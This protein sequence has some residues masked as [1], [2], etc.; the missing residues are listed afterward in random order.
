MRD[1]VFKN[2]TSEDKK[3][4]VITTVEVTDQEGVHSIIQRRFICIIKE[5]KGA[6]G[7]TPLPYVYVL[8]ERNHQAQKERFFCRMKGSM[9][10]VNREKVYS[11]AYLH[12]L[13]ISLTA[14]PQDLAR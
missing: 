1:L 7:E 3:R 14:I 6:P 2:L 5:I 13:K 11:V 12:S 8:K 9:Y 4:R 10:L